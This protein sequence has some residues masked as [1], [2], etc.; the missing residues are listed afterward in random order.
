[1]SWTKISGPEDYLL[2]STNSTNTTVFFTNAGIYTFRL[3]ADD[4]QLQGHADVTAVV[5]ED[6]LSSTNLLHWTFDEGA[7]TN[8]ADAS[9]GGRDGRFVG[10]P[11]W[12]TNGVLGGALNFSGTNDCVRQV[13]NINFLNGLDEFTLSLWLRPGS[14]NF[15]RAFFTAN[16]IGTN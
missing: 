14:T 4:G 3:T 5:V 10:T 13:T 6:L 2:S 8:V 16:D 12:T 7:G 11:V 9:G 1:L 15:S